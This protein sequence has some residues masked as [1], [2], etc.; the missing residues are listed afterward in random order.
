MSETAVSP[1]VETNTVIVLF[2]LLLTTR[3]LC[4]RAW[5]V[6]VSTEGL[7]AVSLIL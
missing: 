5:D 2:I 3:P 7:T 6:L 4:V 1:S